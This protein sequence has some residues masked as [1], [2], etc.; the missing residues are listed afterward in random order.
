MI[1]S[2]LV[3]VGPPGGGALLALRIPEVPT[4]AMFES[5]PAAG[6]TRVIP[7]NLYSPPIL[8]DRNFDISRFLRKLY[9]DLPLLYLRTFADDRCVRI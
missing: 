8:D 1:L 7:G 4:A 5:S 3:G 6:S 2:T 9:P